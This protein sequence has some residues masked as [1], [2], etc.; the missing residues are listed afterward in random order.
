[1]QSVREQKGFDFTAECQAHLV[2][3]LEEL[4]LPILWYFQSHFCEALALVEWLR[5][6]ERVSS[7]ECLS[8][9]DE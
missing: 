3:I 6:V 4:H 7:V 9:D 8:V 5:W 2:T 1:M